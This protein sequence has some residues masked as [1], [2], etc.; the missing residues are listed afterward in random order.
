ML[1]PDRSEGDV[2]EG[3]PERDLLIGVTSVRSKD[4][5]DAS[6]SVYTRIDAF[7]DWIL[8]IIDEEEVNHSINLL[9]F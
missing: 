8:E 5:D 2:S 1:I 7:R 4:C 3:S 6:P 9:L